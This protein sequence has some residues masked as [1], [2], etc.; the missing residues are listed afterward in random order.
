[1]QSPPL[2]V[3]LT[4]ASPAPSSPR[5][6]GGQP[7]GGSQFSAALSR[8]MVQQKPAPAPKSVPPAKAAAPQ[9]AARPAQ[10]EKPAQPDQAAAPGAPAKAADAAAQTADD[11]ADR[12]AADAAAAA[13]GNPLYELMAMVASFNQAP[14][15]PATPA[16]AAAT[17][18]LPTTAAQ[19]GVTV[20]P[21]A[22]ALS[23]ASARLTGQQAMPDVAPALPGNVAPEASFSN[24]MGKVDGAMQEGLETAAAA[25]GQPRP[26][27]SVAAQGVPQERAPVAEA[28]RDTGA[29]HGAPTPAP[30]ALTSVREALPEPVAL[31][32]A[33]VAAAVTIAPVQQASL[34]LPQ[35]GAIQA[36]DRIAARVGTPGWDNQ[37]AQKIVWMVAGKEQS[38]TLTLNPPDMGP[39]QVVLSVNND[40]ASVT[41]SAAQPEVRQALQDA[42]PKLREMMGE[43][44]IALGNASVHDGS[45][46]GQQQQA[47][48]EAQGSGNAGAAPAPAPASGSAAEAEARMAARPLRSGELPGLVNTFA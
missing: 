48:G 13:A 26:Q 11:G 24:M 31:K 5:N 23:A 19:P 47:R 20:A 36:A 37:V 12:A 35:A 44:G 17:A 41:F 46:N 32:E 39:M 10:A 45:A 34:A 4:S 30:L 14:A 40:Q 15:T 1:M 21:D 6:Q 33:P 3:Q 27:Q 25:L 8:E 29:V 42:M 18:A 38:A 7:D 16:P 22:A 2:P 28:V 43:S 9:Q